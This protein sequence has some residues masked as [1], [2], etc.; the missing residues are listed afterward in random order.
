MQD[1]CIQKR[2]IVIILVFFTILILCVYIGA[3]CSYFV[4]L[5]LSSE[6]PLIRTRSRYTPTGNP[7]LLIAIILS[8]LVWGY[9]L[10][11]TCVFPP[12]CIERE[13]KLITIVFF[14]VTLFFLFLFGV[15]IRCKNKTIDQSV[16]TR[17]S[18]YSDT[19]Q[20]THTGPVVATLF[21]DYNQKKQ[22]MDNKHEE[23]S[24]DKPDS[25]VVV[26]LPRL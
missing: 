10:I 18:V 3:A 24:M 1:D 12:R 4:K 21:M 15:C 20:N 16:T 19:P 22:S 2:G 5:S 11:C 26:H 8:V 9:V 6:C 7:H 13:G 14:S 25:I 17:Q 23:Q